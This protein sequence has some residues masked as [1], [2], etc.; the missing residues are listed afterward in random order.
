MSLSERVAMRARHLT[1]LKD[2]HKEHGCPEGGDWMVNAIL[3]A[4]EIAVDVALAKATTQQAA[5]EP[6][7]S[8]TSNGADPRMNLTIKDFSIPRGESK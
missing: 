2:C 4:M 1:I 5:F 7:A 8:L 6:I 3:D